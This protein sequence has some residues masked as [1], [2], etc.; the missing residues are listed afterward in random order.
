MKIRVVSLCLLSMAL[1]LPA[2]NRKDDTTRVGGS[3]FPSAPPQGSAI[4][5]GTVFDLA[6]GLSV[7][8]VEVSFGSEHK[9]RTDKEG[10][11]QIG[12]LEIGAKGEARVRSADGREASQVVLPLGHER[13][14]IVLNIPAR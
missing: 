14:E 12:G 11:F 10:R 5:C 7:A 13:R 1:V 4:L 6:T 8:D 3:S 2:C 9:A